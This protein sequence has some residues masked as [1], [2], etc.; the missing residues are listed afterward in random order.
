MK[1]RQLQELNRH[2]IEAFKNLPKTPLVLVL[3]NIRSALNVGSIFRTSDAFALAGIH[4]CGITAQPPHREIL[5]TAIGATESVDWQYFPHTVDSLAQLRQKGYRLIGIEQT[6][7]STLLQEFQLESS[8]PCALVFGNEV[9]G[10]ADE[11]LPLLDGC[12]E[13]P[14]F[15]TKHSLNVAVCVG[16]VVWHLLQA[17]IKR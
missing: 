1:K 8:Q 4:L 2:S 10:L 3:D 14:Q 12:I 11:V 6:D 16:I 15:G 9:G 13:I 5:K 7:A 17:L